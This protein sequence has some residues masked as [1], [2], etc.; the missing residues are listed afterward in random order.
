MNK[1][2]Q[3][4]TNPSEPISATPS[5]SISTPTPISNAETNPSEPSQAIQ[6]SPKKRKLGKVYSKAWNDYEQLEENGC[7]MAICHYCKTKLKADPKNGT[8][9]LKSHSQRCKK[10]RS[11]DI[12][13][14]LQIATSK[15]VDG[16]M[17]LGN[18][19]FDQEI[20]RR[21]LANAIVLHEYPLSIVDHVGFRKFVGSLQPLFKMV[22][23]NTIKSD[24]L[25]I[26]REEKTKA[27]T[28]F[29]KLSSR[30]AITTDMW[31]SKQKRGYMAIT[32]HFLDRSWCLRSTIIG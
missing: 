29:E 21:E 18:Y 2:V 5:N 19:T 15:C 25:K 12:R 3:D 28:M 31:S 20:S 30:V 1:S 17:K 6:I 10:R 32:A 22:S 23:R 24:I 4:E 14:Q 13:E 9:T 11:V 7:K 27:Y 26:F 16:K 8:S